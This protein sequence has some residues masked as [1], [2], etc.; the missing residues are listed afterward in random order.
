MIKLVP[1]RTAWQGMNCAMDY[2]WAVL[3]DFDKS[4]Q[5]HTVECVD[6]VQ[7]CADGNGNLLLY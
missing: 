6:K 1:I 4:I 2:F 7:V 5:S 3:L